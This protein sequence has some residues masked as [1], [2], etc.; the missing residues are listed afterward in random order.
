MRRCPKCTDVKQDDQFP[1]T[2]STR[3]GKRIYLSICRDCKREADR[4]RIRKICKTNE[5][6][7]KYAEY[8]NR[9][10]VKLRRKE[11]QILKNPPSRRIYIKECDNC[12][13]AFVARQNRARFC[14]EVCARRDRYK[15]N[16][17]EIL[18]RDKKRKLTTIYGT[19]IRNCNVCNKEYDFLK[20]GSGKFCSDVCQDKNKKYAKKAFGHTHRKRARFY[21]VI[22]TSVN[23]NKVFARDKWTCKI[24]GIKTPMRNMGKQLDNSPELDHVIP[25]SKGGPH[26]YTNVQCS[27]RQCNIMKGDSLVG[28]LKLAI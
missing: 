14:S 17:K 6:K 19:T 9:P 25:L 26:T 12:H 21:G 16:K 18:L 28:Q 8:K 4:Q 2:W 1:I 20:Q 23:K 24:C 3:E 5:Y 10:E 22:Y 27:C 15:N 13:T 7:V 11:Q